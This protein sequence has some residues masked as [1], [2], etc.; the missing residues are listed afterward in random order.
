MVRQKKIGMIGAGSMAEALIQGLVKEGK[1]SPRQIHVTNRSRKERLKELSDRYGI[2]P[3]TDN[4]V[5]KEMDILILAI[6][7][8]DAAE[9]LFP[10]KAYLHRKQ[11]M[12][13][14]MAG[15]SMDYLLRL[16]GFRLPIIRTMPNTSSAIG[17]SATAI[18]VGPHCSQENVEDAEEIF[19]AIGSVTWVKEEDLDAVTALSGSGPA[20]IYY[21][22]EAMEQAGIEVGLSPQI[23]RELTL[24]TLLGAAHMLIE[25]G[26]E[27]SI[28]RTKIMSPGGT[29][30]AGIEF[31]NQSKFQEAVKGAVLSAWKR[32]L[33]IR[34]SFEKKKE[35]VL[36][37]LQTQSK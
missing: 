16:V 36:P 15:V 22:V 1:V 8:K 18:A 32:S 34:N 2:E 6:K 21:L 9:A 3:V 5:L 12:I 13:S 24:K 27:P 7:P 31:L 17:L 23:S 37:P 33:E 14:M 10:I 29:T 11:L 28:L 20:Y 19:K 26:E 25:T 4:S 35:E 30:V